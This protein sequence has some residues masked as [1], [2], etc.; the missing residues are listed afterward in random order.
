MSTKY[1]RYSLTRNNYSNILIADK[2]EIFTEINN[3]FINVGKIIFD[4]IKA[5]KY[6]KFSCKELNKNCHNI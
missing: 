5:N 1:I 6:N 3:Y 2:Y 4:E